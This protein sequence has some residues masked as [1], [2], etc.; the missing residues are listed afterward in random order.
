MAAVIVL[1]HAI[2]GIV[3]FGGLF[4]RGIVLALGFVAGAFPAIQAMRLRIVGALRRNA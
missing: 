2:L 4:G 3:F 1:A